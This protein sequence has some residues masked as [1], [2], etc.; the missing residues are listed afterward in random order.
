ML[1]AADKKA[2]ILCLLKVLEQYTDCEHALTYEEIAA[3]IERDFGL[4]KPS[5]NTIANNIR[6]LR[7]GFSYDI[8]KG[9]GGSGVYLQERIL[10]GLQTKIL[11]S[12]LATAKSLTDD[13]AQQLIKA[14]ESLN[15]RHFRGLH[16]TSSVKSYIHQKNKEI[17][18]NLALLDE[19]IAKGVQISFIY[20]DINVKGELTPRMKDGRKLEYQVHPFAMACVDGFYYLIGSAFAYKELRHYRIDHITGMRLLENC[21]RAS[22]SSMK[23][24]ENTAYFNLADYVRQHVLMFNGEVIRVK[25]QGEQALTN[26]LW[27]VFGDRAEIKELKNA[28]GKIE[29]TVRTT[30]GAAKIFAK[31]YC[32]LCRL[33]APENLRQELKKEFAEVAQKY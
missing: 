24:Y 28:P 18:S 22:L 27:D 9:R 31:Q 8:V 5:R 20:N 7:D 10:S 17:F 1:D 32:N 21:K 2:I 16:N 12:Q 29:F 15:S 23:G 33:V 26:Y 19:A 30:A 3:K 6:L 25:F 11:V 4:A 14:L 13:N